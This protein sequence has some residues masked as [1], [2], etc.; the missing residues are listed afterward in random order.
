MRN[1]P[2]RVSSQ[3]G[4]RALGEIA[5][6]RDAAEA[7][8][9]VHDEAAERGGMRCDDAAT[10]CWNV[11]RCSARNILHCAIYISRACVDACERACVCV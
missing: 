7:E 10:P 11:V 6:A 5:Q 9:E 1:V 8:A 2:Y 3:A 4:G